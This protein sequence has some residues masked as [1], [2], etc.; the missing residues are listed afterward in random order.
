MFLTLSF[1]CKLRKLRL[2]PSLRDP[3]FTRSIHGANMDRRHQHGIWQQHRPQTSIWLLAATQTI[4]I[5]LASRCISGQEHQHGY[6]RQ[7]RPSTSTYALMIVGPQTPTWSQEAAWLTGTYMALKD[8]THHRRKHGLW[9]QHKPLL[10]CQLGSTFSGRACTSS[11]LLQ[12]ILP[13]LL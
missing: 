9:W 12:T 1:R 5:N 4:N 2:L 7:P 6:Q 11:R 10:R 3:M 8:H 13:V